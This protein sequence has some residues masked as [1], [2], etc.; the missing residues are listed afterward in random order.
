LPLISALNLVLQQ[1]PADM[2]VRVGKNRYFFPLSG[3]PAMD[4][5]LG[6]EACQGFFTSVR[7]TYKQLMV[8][9]N[10]CMT[11]FY[12]RG[13]LAEAIIAFSRSSLGAMPRRFSQGIKVTTTHLGYK[14]RKPL[15]RITDKPASQTFF[16]HDKYGRISVEQYFKRGMFPT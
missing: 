4:L 14:M 10:V 16:E 3:M 6:V 5:G 7:P 9:V 12:T 8:N 13:N 11:A 1:Q 15:K 2:G